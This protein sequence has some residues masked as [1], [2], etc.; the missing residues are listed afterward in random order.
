M[1]WRMALAVAGASALVATL[2]VGAPDPRD[3]PSLSAKDLAR[4]FA[5]YAA[6]VRSCYAANA[7]S[8]EATGALR[9][10][11]II[12][13]TGFVSQFGFA[14]PGVV[15]PWRARLD[16]CLR[17]QAKVWHFPVRRGSTSAV[18]PFLF[19]RT[20]VVGAGPFESC[21]DPRGCPPKKGGTR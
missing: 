1:W 14:A 16:G 4:Y 2:A 15:A 13:R 6:D 9:L 12:E 11:L 17:E 10:E 21:W 8:K 20:T 5:P 7:K 18:V 19:T 3:E